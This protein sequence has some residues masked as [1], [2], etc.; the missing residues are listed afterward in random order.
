VTTASN[1]IISLPIYDSVPALT[2]AGNQANVTIVG[3]LQVFVNQVNADGSL[4]VT[5]LNV[6]G[7]GNGTTPVNT[8]VFGNSPVPVRLITPP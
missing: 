1:S 8:A 7:C 6:S 3:F 4:N 2:F 5:V